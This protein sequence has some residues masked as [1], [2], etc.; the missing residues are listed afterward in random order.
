MRG[1]PAPA[2]GGLLERFAVGHREMAMLRYY[3]GVLERLGTDV[4]SGD[5]AVLALI[6]LIVAERS[7]F[8]WPGL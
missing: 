6:R 5:F 8:G 4:L 7:R 1:S 3:A 2:Q